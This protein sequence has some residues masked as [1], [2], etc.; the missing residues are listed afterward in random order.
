MVEQWDPLTMHIDV[1]SMQ[2]SIWAVGKNFQNFIFSPPLISMISFSKHQYERH[3]SKWLVGMGWVK[4]RPE[5]ILANPTRA[6]FLWTRATR[7]YWYR[8]MWKKARYPALYLTFQADFEQWYALPKL[9]KLFLFNFWSFWVVPLILMFA[10][11]NH[12][13]ERWGKNRILEVFFHRSY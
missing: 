9:T 13:H 1:C 2:T 6:I 10:K 5:V 3:C 4:T 8:L 11:C 7:V 12:Q